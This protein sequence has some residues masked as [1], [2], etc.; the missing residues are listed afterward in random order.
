MTF[1]LSAIAVLSGLPNLDQIHLSGC[2]TYCPG[3]DKVFPWTTSGSLELVVVSKTELSE[4]PS[5]VSSSY[6]NQQGTMEMR[7]DVLSRVGAQNM[8]KSLS[9]VSDPE[10]IHFENDQL[11]VDAV[12]KLG[13]DTFSL[14]AFRDS[15]MGESAEKHILIH[16]EK[17]KETCPTAA[18]SEIHDPLFC[19]KVVHLERED[20]MF[21][22]QFIEV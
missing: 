6:P 16:N 1:F 17:D 20:K 12:F 15:E 10:N 22:N 13:F 11:E 19:W 4:Q 18:I 8:D 5:S 9:Q 21:L 7:D 14:T 3:N 2:I